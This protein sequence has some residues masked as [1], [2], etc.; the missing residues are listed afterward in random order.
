VK[1][2]K[3]GKI[4]KQLRVEIM[5]SQKFKNIS[6]SQAFVTNR[7]SRDKMTLAKDMRGLCKDL[8]KLLKSHSLILYLSSGHSIVLGDKSGES[9]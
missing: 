3:L 1:P 8:K 4:E 2:S 6:N 5:K 9:C 7:L